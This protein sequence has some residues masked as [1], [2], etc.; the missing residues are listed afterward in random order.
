MLMMALSMRY[1]YICQ[2]CTD[3]ICFSNCLYYAFEQYSKIS[4]LCFII[5]SVVP[6]Y[7][8]QQYNKLLT[9]CLLAM[10]TL[11][12]QSLPIILAIYIFNALA[13]LLCLKSCW[14]NWHRPNI[15]DLPSKIYIAIV[16]TA[17]SSI[18]E[19]AILKMGSYSWLW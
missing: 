13:C 18:Q 12:S 2:A 5:C 1:S 9:V 3:Y 15:C 4:L 7:A 14:Y 19:T 11:C 8:P 17:L 16:R 10:P 6:S